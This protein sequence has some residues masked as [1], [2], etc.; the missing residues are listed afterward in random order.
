M[1]SGSGLIRYAGE[2]GVVWRIKYRD[3]TGRQVM[4]TVGA[5]RD[6]V[7]KK[8]AEA[9]LRERLVRVERKRYVKPAPLTFEGFAERWFAEGESRRQWKTST[10]REYR[11]VRRRL[12]A[13]LGNIPI[14]TIRPS[15]VAAFVSEGSRTL[16]AATVSRDLSVLHAIFETARLEEVVDSNPAARA[17]RPKLP[18]Q[19]WRILEPAEVAAVARAFVDEQARVVFLTLILTGLRRSE[20]QALRW[21]D[22]DLIDDVLRVRD[23]KSEEGIRS[24]ALSSGLVE[25][26]WQRRRTSQFQAD[27]D[28]VF[29]HPERGTVY[30]ADVFRHALR[31]ALAAAG[32][33]A[34]LRPFHDLRHASLTNGAAAGENPVALMARAGH[35]SMRTTERYVHLAGIVFRDEASALERRLFGTADVSTDASTAMRKTSRSR[36]VS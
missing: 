4:E 11:S 33:E 16:G 14:A 23:S 22:V 19:R 20:L 5:E 12:V 25:Q 31:A 1:P 9:E 18:R 8:N 32:V 13:N 26:L 27:D 6:G 2:R 28:R 15:H 24:I 21:R 36:G 17:E 30:R 10:V 35:R 7:T 34:K 3:A 29:C